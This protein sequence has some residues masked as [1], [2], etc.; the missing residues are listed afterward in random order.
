MAYRCG[1][2]PR[3]AR[4]SY[5]FAPDLLVDADGAPLVAEGDDKLSTATDDL[6][7]V[8]AY[9]ESKGIASE[10]DP[11]SVAGDQFVA[12]A[13]WLDTYS[14]ARPGPDVVLT[15]ICLAD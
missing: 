5:S 13:D 8:R 10:A 4:S 12:Q 6:D 9:W 15:T 11:A 14:F 3:T 1:P 7:G 2:W